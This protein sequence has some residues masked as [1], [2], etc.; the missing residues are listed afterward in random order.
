MVKGA[1]RM[2]GAILPAI[3]C[4]YL[5]AIELLRVAATI[6]ELHVRQTETVVGALHAPE[7]PAS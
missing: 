1:S 6:V 2:T 3:R 5:K 7:D 4:S